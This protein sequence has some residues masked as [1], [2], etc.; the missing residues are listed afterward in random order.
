[1]GILL[2]ADLLRFPKMA[3]LQVNLATGLCLTF[4]YPIPFF[5]KWLRWLAT[6]KLFLLETHYLV[7]LKEHHNSCDQ[8]HAN[9]L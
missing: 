9:D 7:H 2:L 5:S 3:F 1:M 4:I 8:G 6:Q